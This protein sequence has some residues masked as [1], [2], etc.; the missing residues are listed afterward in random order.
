MIDKDLNK[1]NKLD[2]LNKLN[3]RDPYTTYIN[4]LYLIR[5]K[6]DVKIKHQMLSKWFKYNNKW[7]III[8]FTNSK[9]YDMFQRTKGI[10]VNIYDHYVISNKREMANVLKYLEY[11]DSKGINNNINRYNLSLIFSIKDYLIHYDEQKNWIINTI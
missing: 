3:K 2:K 6:K 11:I 9:K 5:D 8:D 7:L 1:L 4:N 10:T